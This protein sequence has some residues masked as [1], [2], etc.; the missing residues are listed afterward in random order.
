MKNKRI[1]IFIPAPAGGGAEISMI[2]LANGLAEK[3]YLVD[4]IVK[5]KQGELAGE[6]QKSVNVIDFNVPILRYT[7]P[8]LIAYRK[9]YQPKAIISALELPNIVNVLAKAAAGGTTRTIISIHGTQSKQPIFYQKYF[10]RVL[11]AILYPWSD[12]IV[13]VSHDSARDAIRY[14]SLPASKVKVIYNPIISKQFYEKAKEPAPPHEWL[15]STEKKIVLSIGRLESVKD[16]KTLIQAFALIHARHPSKLVIL[17]EGSL[18]DDL[19]KI[20]TSLGL[21]KDVIFPGYIR[22]PFS[23]IS[24]S[25]VFV[26]SSLYEGLPTVLIEALACRCPIVSTDIGSARE[27]LN[28]GQYG[29]LTPVGDAEAMARAIQKT[30]DG[31]TRLAPKEWLSQFEVEKNVEQYI[32]LIEN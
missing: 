23:I 27:I 25:D 3:G 31:D 29:H 32:D 5:Q 4:L 24:H 10:D 8:K 1:G 15:D 19:E 16:H 13:C 20:A 18:R 14:L 7:L 22:Q 26:L 11:W 30:L 12:V 2:F 6:I 17:G 28:Y 21:E 9:E